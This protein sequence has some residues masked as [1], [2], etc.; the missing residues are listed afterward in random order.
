MRSVNGVTFPGLLKRL[1]WAPTLCGCPS[2]LP[3]TDW[4]FS[5]ER[6]LLGW[7]HSL[8]SWVA[9][10][11]VNAEPKQSMWQAWNFLCILPTFLIFFPLVQGLPLTP[12]L[13]TRRCHFCML[14][15]TLL[16]T[17]WTKL[18]RICGCIHSAP[19]RH[20]EDGPE[21]VSLYTC[22][23][24]KQKVNLCSYTSIEQCWPPSTLSGADKAVVSSLWY[25][26]FT[27]TGQY[28][29][30]HQDFII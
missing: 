11:S 21:D 9:W 3:L 25:A 30:L 12:E 26:L 7:I 18:S 8:A 5:R 6:L 17:L 20:W 14:L 24:A 13:V 4:H 28:E 16:A 23:V 22:T 19:G 2:A 15:S 27:L 10:C 29:C 1:R